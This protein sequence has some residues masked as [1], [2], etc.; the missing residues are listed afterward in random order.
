MWI[1]CQCCGREYPQNYDWYVCDKCGYRICPHCLTS[2]GIGS[3][4]GNGYKCSQ[5]AYGHL[6][7]V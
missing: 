4:Y 3:R 7:K 6:D 5:C 1:R 2:H